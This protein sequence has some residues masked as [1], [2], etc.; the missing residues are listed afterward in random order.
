[1]LLRGSGLKTQTNFNVN[2]VTDGAATAGI[3]N[4][5]TIRSLVDT[6]MA[7]DWQSLAAIRTQATKEI[8][9]Q[10]VADVLTVAAGFNGITRVANATGIPLDPSTAEATSEM[11]YSANIN[12]FDEP[13]KLEKY[14]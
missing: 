10:A 3:E 13:R 5:A 7:G 9:I 14:G 11:R 8:G 1:M 4:E 2:A 12:D 6:F